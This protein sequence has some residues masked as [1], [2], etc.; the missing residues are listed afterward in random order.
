MMKEINVE[1]YWPGVWR[2]IQA[3]HPSVKAKFITNIGED[4][5]EKI[6]AAAKRVEEEEKNARVS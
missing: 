2:H 3:L 6:R 1:P 4:E 5:Y